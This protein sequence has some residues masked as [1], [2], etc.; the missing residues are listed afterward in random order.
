M[1]KVKLAIPVDNGVLS[2][3]FG[4]T[5]LFEFFEIVD[6]KIMHNE[7]LIPPPHEEGVLP[8]W[9]IDNGVTDLL[10]GGIGPKAI[11]I[12][13]NKGINVYVGVEKDRAENLAL[14]FINDSL[15]FGKNYCHH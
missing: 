9:L 10:T 13:Y 1:S 3:H 14:N 5:R 12:L 11:N 2:E 8:R 7:Q 4:H 15:S 6:K